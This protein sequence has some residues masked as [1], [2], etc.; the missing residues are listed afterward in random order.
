M[1]S[2]PKEVPRKNST[3]WQVWWYNP[4]GVLPKHTHR[5]FGSEAMAWKFKRLVEIDSRTPNGRK[6]P[7][8]HDREPTEAELL[9]EGIITVEQVDQANAKLTAA[10]MRAANADADR[11][12]TVDEAMGRY[13]HF[14]EFGEVQR[15][16]TATSAKSLI[17]NR[18]NYITGTALGACDVATADRRDVQAWV[19]E[20]KNRVQRNGSGKVGIS[21]KS[22]NNVM[23][24][25][26]AMFIWATTEKSGDGHS[27]I[28]LR[29]LPNPMLDVVRFDNVKNADDE[30][31][32]MHR[33]DEYEAVFRIAYGINHDWADMLAFAALTALRFGEFSA[34]TVEQMLEWD[35]AQNMP[36]VF[37]IDR[38]MSR[39]KPEWG[40]KGTRRGGTPL[41]RRVR[42]PEVMW[43]M[44]VQRCEGKRPTD[45]IFDG[46]NTL[47]STKGQWVASTS[48]RYWEQLSDQLPANGLG[49][50]NRTYI[51]KD[52]NRVVQPFRAHN[53][54]HSLTT[55]L[56]TKK[57]ELTI[58]KQILGHRD[59]SVH[60]MYEH[61][62][63]QDWEDLITVT[64]P[65][66]EA[67]M[68][69]RKAAYRDQ[70]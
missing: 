61:M 2:N 24:D 36:H 19:N 35:Y 16:P 56:R 17:S 4:P 29:T 50:L 57:V 5:S 22:M 27:V 62:T 54:R 39:G 48:A 70:G 49:H 7:G 66:A 20:Q 30:K 1:A 63:P 10:E 15:R 46:P 51:D 32:V 11:I 55:W 26:S 8:G 3:A 43:E 41:T 40:T 25:L 31:R 64:G 65:I 42:V 21:E 34:L 60:G 68:R 23:A 18:R 38:R 37:L 47:A 53:L 6:I 52:G 45:L 12:V 44:M 67:I 28:R 9:R 59:K 13:I 33:E 14:K 69:A 58:R